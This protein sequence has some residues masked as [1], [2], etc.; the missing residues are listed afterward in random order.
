MSKLSKADETRILDALGDVRELLDSG[1]APND[2]ICKVA[3][4]FQM[5]PNFVQLMINAVNTGRTNE[6]RQEAAGDVYKAAE[7]FPLAEP[8][9]ILEKLFP[10]K[11]KTAGQVH[12]DTVVSEVYSSP[13]RA[14]R[15]WTEKAAADK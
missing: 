9:V 8:A 14:Q 11:V 13:S 10:A 1:T 5:R 4:D 3:A 7:S 12:R 2:A 15:F 6:H